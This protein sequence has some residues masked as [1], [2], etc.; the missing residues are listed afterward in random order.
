MEQNLEDRLN[1]ELD[2]RL[3]DAVLD[4]R[5]AQRPRRPIA[6]GDLNPPDR[7]RAVLPRP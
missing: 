7:L 3:H 1:D 4:R 6:L 2:R 5:N